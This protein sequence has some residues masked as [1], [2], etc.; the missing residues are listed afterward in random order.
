MPVKKEYPDKESC[1]YFEAGKCR[2]YQGECFHDDPE[3]HENRCYKLVPRW[4]PYEFMEWMGDLC[5]DCNEPE[6]NDCNM[7]IEY[8]EK[9]RAAEKPE[10]HRPELIDVPLSAF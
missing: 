1:D 10:K 3:G 7:F 2:L 9:L 8:M 5:S 6:C 4:R